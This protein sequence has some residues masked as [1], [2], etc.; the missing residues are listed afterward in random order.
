LH[1]NRRR[2]CHQPDAVGQGLRVLTCDRHE[3]LLL[4]QLHGS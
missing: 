1:E 4:L 2:A 3:G